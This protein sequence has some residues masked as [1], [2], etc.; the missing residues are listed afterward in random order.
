MMPSELVQHSCLLSQL[1]TSLMSLLG[2]K[3]DAKVNDCRHT[4]HQGPH[5][6]HPGF[7][8]RRLQPGPQRSLNAGILG[9]AVGLNPALD[10][11]TLY[12]QP[13]SRSGLQCTPLRGSGPELRRLGVLPAHTQGS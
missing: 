1:R 11:F 5:R 13:A 9:W 6:Q 7:A 2:P 10:Q 8:G 3:I 12:L 4:T